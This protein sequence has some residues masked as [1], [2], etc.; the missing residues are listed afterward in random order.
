MRR[1]VLTG[2]IL[3]IISVVI[4]LNIFFQQIYEREMAQ[5]LNRQQ[6]LIARA[7]SSNIQSNF[8]HIEE[9]LVGFL[10]LLRR[11][12][13]GTE[14][15]A[16]F[17]ADA[18]AEEGEEHGVILK[19]FD[20]EGRLL[21]PDGL[22]PT[23]EDLRMLRL[24]EAVKP[25]RL[26][27]FDH[28]REH[29]AVEIL[30]PFGAG[31]G[32]REAVALVRLGI[33]VISE[34]FLA[35]ITSGERG[36]AW[37]MDASGTLIYHPTMPEM[38]GKNIFDA[39]ASC[40]LCHTSFKTEE[41]ILRSRDI[42]FASYVAPRGEDKLVAF[43]R[44]KL[45]SISWIVCVTI[46]HSEVTASIQQSMRVHAVLVL[47]IIAMTVVG[48]SIVVL[49]NRSRI[50]AEE[51]ARHLEKQKALEHEILHAKNYLENI[52]E[53]TQ[54]VIMVIDADMRIRT[55]NTACESLCTLRKEEILSASFLD[56]FPFAAPS[57]RAM[58]ER[59]L[60]ACLEGE[61][62]H[63][64]EYPVRCRGEIRSLNIILSP[65]RIHGA[66]TSIILSANDVT[67]ETRL[68]EKIR[69]YAQELEALVAERTRELKGEKEKL[70]AL[71]QSIGSGMA[72]FDAGRRLVWANRVFKDWLP[73]GHEG[74]GLT[75]DDV[76]AGKHPDKDLKDAILADGE[77]RSHVLYRDFGRKAGY[78][79]MTLTP[80]HGTGGEEQVLLLIQD[81]TEVR[82][83]EEQM[84][85]SEKLSALARLSAGVAHEIGNPLTSISSYVQILK[86]MDFDEFTREALDTISR[87]IERITVIV[88]QMSSFTK[89][90]TGE[91]AREDVC[92]IIESTLRLVRYDRRMKK[93]EIS[94]EFPDEVPPVLVN[95]D[96]LEQVL[97]NLV[98]N[99]GDAM[100]DG[101]K[102][103]ISVVAAGGHVDI[104]CR[105]TGHGI[106]AEQ[107]E[108]IFNPFFTTKESG[109]GLGLSV[110]Y[111]IV[112]SF[113][114]T[115]LVSSRPGEGTT[116]TVRLPV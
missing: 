18:F 102:L 25:G 89:A 46:P 40:F 106:P 19:I 84:M 73:A 65:L 69:Q 30:A 88:R 55:V 1:I 47:F 81:V 57:D 94:T 71:V 50:K 90:R 100:P 87:H 53:S 70:N 49:N 32:Q 7:V 27:F 43:S 113:G 68:K 17:V 38:V 54:T 29:R 97:I 77:G 61:V 10:R 33:D 72:I 39:D 115:I 114:G 101:G 96:Q 80:L 13:L 105:D 52:L 64:T 92:H 98:L 63:V 24:S 5:Q 104:L 44:V 11:R 59:T 34:K 76:F 2:F 58:F 91:P 14:G 67:E 9:E 93:V 45:S 22:R 3:L 85:Q 48:A 42:G 15:L 12:G 20:R 111:T 41:R 112:R 66:I 60:Q 78:F 74:E 82:R 23:P 16:E 86:G 56:V 110:S 8:E 116:F 107:L 31:E 62:R 21:F 75:L 83:A 95:A 108:Q 35:P 4:T 51:K 99:A 103:R 79:Q 26:A 6:L 36:Y 28:V 109:T 37:M